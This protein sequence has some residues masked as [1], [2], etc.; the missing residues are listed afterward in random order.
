MEYFDYLI[1][2]QGLAGTLL[3]HFLLKENK[4]ILLV[5][6][7][8]S[9]ASKIAP[10]MFNPI[11]GRRMTKSW[12]I[13]EA[14]P[15]SFQTYRNLETELN[16]QFFHPTP[17]LRFFGDEKDK[18]ATINSLKNSDSEK[19]VNEYFELKRVKGFCDDFPNGCVL[20]QTGFLD[21]F[22][23]LTS[24]A[25]S[26]SAHIVH[27][28]FD[29]PELKIAGSE[30]QWNGRV[31]G[32][33]IFCEGFRGAANPLFSY[34]PWNLAKGEVLT[35]YSPD[36]ELDSIYN[37]GLYIVPSGN[38]YFRV[39]ATYCWDFENDKPSSE[40]LSELKSKLNSILCSD[41]DIVLHQAGIRPTVIHRRPFLGLHPEEKSIGIFNGLGTKGVI[42]APYLAKHLVDHLERNVPLI[43]EVN[44]MR[45]PHHASSHI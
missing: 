39:G 16:A 30:I 42:L 5:D 44:I 7:G 21:T 11:A 12:K 22:T 6:H 14:Y 2:G 40:G 9:N 28:A 41:Y 19:Y 10:G 34:L 45:Y 31:F 15:V 33:V 20:Q 3:S 13:D 32:R 25:E 17:M 8:E 4:K 38:G 36:L 26:N 29:L 18:E 24:W 43:T 27:A 35:I 1:I 23:F 37:R